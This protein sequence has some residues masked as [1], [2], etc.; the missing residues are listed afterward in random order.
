MLRECFQKNLIELSY[1]L[2]RNPYFLVKKKEENKYRLINN[3]MEINWVI[4]RDGNLPPT[5]NEFSG[6]FGNYI[7]ILLINFFSGYNQ[8]KLDEKS[9]DLINFYTSIRFY[10]MI[11]LP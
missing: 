4:I 10:R 2:Y 6:E 9:R 3:V 5:I 8:I 7:I 11:I 1:A